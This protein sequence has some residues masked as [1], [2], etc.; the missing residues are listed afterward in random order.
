MKRVGWG[1]PFLS[2]MVLCGS[3][4]ANAD[5]LERGDYLMNTIVAC[6]NCHTPM[7][8][9]GAVADRELA[10]RL[11]ED[12]DPWTA[13][14]PNITPDVATGI[15]GW[16]DAEIVRAI[17]EGVRPD[18]SI[19]GPPMPIALYR[20]LSDEDAAAL[21]AYI[22]AMP[23]VENAVPDS[24]YRIPLPPGYGPPLET[25]AAPDPS[26]TLAYGAYL[27][28]P[29]GHCVECHSTPDERGVPDIVNGLGGGGMA[30][31]G[32]WGTSVAANLTPTHLGDWTDEEIA[33]V[34]RTGVRPDG[35]RLLPPMG[36][37]Y[38]AGI[39]EDDMAA[40]IVYLRSLPPL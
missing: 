4:Q 34:I 31:H 5:L 15:G 19:I 40:L 14:A 8:P 32:P 7:G 28:G 17:R 1:L 36:V 13:Y 18:G 20:G 3:A 6:G 27:A 23:A 24:T 12:G 16:T 38:Y 37:G 11:L 33:T 21:V 35:S 30:F 25:V 10:G 2:A 22:R 26:D 9:D 29:L 39:A